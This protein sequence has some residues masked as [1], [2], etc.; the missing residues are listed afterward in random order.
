M[1]IV[2]SGDSGDSGDIADRITTT[3]QERL[4]L[5]GGWEDDTRCELIE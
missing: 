1:D 5:H 4:T 2:G 3:G